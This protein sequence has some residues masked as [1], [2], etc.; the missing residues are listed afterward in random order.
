MVVQFYSREAYYPIMKSIR[1][2]N[3]FRLIIWK[4]MKNGLQIAI[5]VFMIKDKIAFSLICDIINV[6]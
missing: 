4:C 3:S 1:F 6:T 5:M 2:K